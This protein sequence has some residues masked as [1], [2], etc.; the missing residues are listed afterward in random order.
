[1]EIEVIGEATEDTCEQFQKEECWNQFID[2]NNSIQDSI[3]IDSNS[4]CE[5]QSSGC[6][7]LFFPF[8]S[9][10]I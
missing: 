6:S 9:H 10:V 8:L 5:F 7:I 4:L 2:V 1:M 3:A